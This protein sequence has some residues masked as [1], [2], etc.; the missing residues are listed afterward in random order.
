MRIIVF[1]LILFISAT[2][3]AQ[4]KKELLA[5]KVK[6]QAEM[7]K[8]INETSALKAQI[9]ES[10]KPKEVSLSNDDKKAGYSIGVLMA[11]NLKTQGGDSL[12][13][14]AL[15]SGIQDVYLNKELKLDQQ[16]CSE[17]AQ[18]YMQ[19]AN[20]KKTIKM[21]ESGIKF[22]NENKTKEG[23]KT[24]AS[25]LQYKV[26]TTGKG[27]TPVASNSVTVHYTGRL[28]DGTVFD[29]SVERGTPATFGVTGV[30]SGWT[31]ALQLMKEGDK[32]TL[33]LP[34]ELAYGSSGAGGV[35]PPHA[36]LIFDVEL[37]KVN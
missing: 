5:E 15:V 35:I 25:G 34:S 31:E 6:L 26:I 12:D 18:T 1:C 13:L 29:S 14:E 11:T 23:I 36:A 7:S 21:K 9:E 20:D 4:S 22:L 16:A 30:I 2:T 28:I 3:F 8:L 27:K 37:I 32:W 19:Q 17:T 10:K 24:T 33:F